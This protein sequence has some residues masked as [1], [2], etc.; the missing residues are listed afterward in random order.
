MGS[1]SIAIKIVVANRSWPK[2]KMASRRGQRNRYL[3][4]LHTTG[5]MSVLI[6]L[7]GRTA[8]SSVPM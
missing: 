7:R 2:P 1:E 4:L 6:F 5:S 3:I 8:G